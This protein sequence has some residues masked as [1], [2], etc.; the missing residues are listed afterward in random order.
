MLARFFALTQATA[1]RP[2]AEGAEV[3]AAGDEAAPAAAVA[4]EH[5]TGEGD[6]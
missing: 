1:F 4:A 5:A 2:A 3:H 6:A